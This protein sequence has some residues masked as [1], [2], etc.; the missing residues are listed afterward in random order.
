MLA[1]PDVA[2]KTSMFPAMDDPAQWV[3]M[4]L[5]PLAVQWWASYY[6]GLNLAGGGYIAQRMFSAKDESHAVATLLFNVAHYAPWPWILIALASI[7]CSPPGGFAGGVP[8]HSCG[9][10]SHDLA[11][12]AMLSLLPEG[13]LGLVAASLL[14]AFMSTMS[15]QLNLASYGQRLLGALHSTGCYRCGA[16]AYGPIGDRGF[17]DAG[18]GSVCC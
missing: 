18:S 2:S 12:P 14:A 11:Y 7:W 8:Q 15:A 1:H 10:I 17:V 5:V 6:P 13:L 3:P 4:L 9:Q 16:G